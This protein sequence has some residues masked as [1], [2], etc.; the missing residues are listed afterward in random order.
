MIFSDASFSLWLCYKIPGY[1][2][3]NELNSSLQESICSHNGKIY[4]DSV[5]SSWCL[6]TR[7]RP[8]SESLVGIALVGFERRIMCSYVPLRLDISHWV[9]LLKPTWQLQQLKGWMSSRNS[10]S[11]RNEV[12]VWHC[13]LC[14]SFRRPSARVSIL[15][16]PVCQVYVSSLCL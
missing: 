14:L 8:S 13:C 16:V 10:S 12:T 6:C 1:S 5:T 3:L 4:P 2:S 11:G 9:N 7:K 15:W